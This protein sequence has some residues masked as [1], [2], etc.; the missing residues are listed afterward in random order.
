MVIN[1]WLPFEN[2]AAY[3]T[4]CKIDMHRRPIMSKYLLLKGNSESG[5]PKETLT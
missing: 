3:G 1:F 5:E 2:A 4:I